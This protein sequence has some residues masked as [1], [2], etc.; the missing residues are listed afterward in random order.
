MCDP[1][2]PEPVGSLCGCSR[3]RDRPLLKY[4]GMEGWGLSQGG[5]IGAVVL[6]RPVH[7][8]S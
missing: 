8:P 5:K 6:S 1:V 4:A 3:G 7:G 2:D